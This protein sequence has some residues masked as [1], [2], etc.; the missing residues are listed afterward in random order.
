MGILIGTT[1]DMATVVATAALTAPAQATAGLQVQGMYNAAVSGTFTGGVRLEKSFDAGVTWVPVWGDGIGTIVTF[2]TPGSA[3]IY[4]PEP[5][6][7]VR[8]AAVTLS[9]GSAAA[10]VSQ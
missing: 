6:V 1:R 9:A 7:L 8:L 10:R 3:L 5:G 2:T 4:E